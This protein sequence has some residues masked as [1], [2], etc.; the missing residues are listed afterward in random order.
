M[1]YAAKMRVTYTLIM[2]VFQAARS[3]SKQSTRYRSFQWRRQRACCQRLIWWFS[4]LRKKKKKTLRKEGLVVGRRGF[5]RFWES[6]EIVSTGFQPVCCAR[7]SWGYSITS[8]ACMTVTATGTVMYTA[9]Q[10]TVRD[11]REQINL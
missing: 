6:R 7:M 11:R 10:S 1:R 3:G 9:A 4:I 8:R 2:M 5:S